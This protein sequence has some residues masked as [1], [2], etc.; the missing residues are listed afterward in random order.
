MVQSL[1][2]NHPSDKGIHEIVSQTISGNRGFEGFGTG[3]SNGVGQEHLADPAGG[4]VED[5]P[6]A[7]YA[8]T[9][10]RE[11]RLHY[12]MKF[13]RRGDGASARRVAEIMEFLGM[14][15]ESKAWWSAA[16][17]LGDPDAI[18]C[19]DYEIAAGELPQF[20]RRIS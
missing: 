7:M 10:T 12:Y 4:P 19:M 3:S 2:Q 11:Q 15:D 16:A 20:I 17:A 13:A 8:L 18:D 6:D 1:S 5:Q 14:E 9:L